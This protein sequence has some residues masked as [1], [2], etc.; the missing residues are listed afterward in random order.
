MNKDFSKYVL[1]VGAVVLLYLVAK[2]FGLI[3]DTQTQRTQEEQLFKNYFSPTYLRQLLQM[4][5]RTQLMTAADM[6]KIA[7]D[8]YDSRGFFNDDESKLY[9]AIKRFRFKSQISQV[10]DHFQKR[11]NKDLAFY[12]ST[13]LNQDELQKVYNFTDSLPSGKV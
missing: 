3:K 12:L 6:Q 2:R 11:Y 10:A 8:L 1:P 7:K 9:G 13:F 4:P 5:G